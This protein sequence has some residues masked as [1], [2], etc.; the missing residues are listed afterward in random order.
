MPTLRNVP[1][2]PATHLYTTGMQ[3]T[4]E[5]SPATDFLAS[6]QAKQT[7]Q[8]HVTPRRKGENHTVVNL[9]FHTSDQPPGMPFTIKMAGCLYQQ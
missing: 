9:S 3:A 8:T 6:S 2:S 1:T 5:I 4:V 7:H